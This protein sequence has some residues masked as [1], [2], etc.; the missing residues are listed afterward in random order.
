MTLL[1]LAIVLGAFDPS[2]T[3]AAV[4]APGYAKHHRRVSKHMRERVYDRDGVPKGQRRG[5]TIDHII[6]LELGGTNALSNL[7]AQ[8]KAEA[9]AKDADENRLH[10]EAC[11]GSITLAD[12]RAEIQRKWKR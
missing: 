9:R 5:W 12:A 2:A 8:P 6:P 10:L 3:S 7:A 1:L 11:A 4:C